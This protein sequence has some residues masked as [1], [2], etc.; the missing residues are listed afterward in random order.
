MTI[1]K[2][3]KSLK[4]EAEISRRV[5]KRIEIRTAN[6]VLYLG[7]VQGGPYPKAI[8]SRLEKNNNI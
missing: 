3:R 5:E 7:T 8:L 4:H 6:G 2:K 1:W